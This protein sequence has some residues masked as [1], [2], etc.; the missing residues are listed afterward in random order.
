MTIDDLTKPLT[1]AQV[2]TALYS[3]MVG[4]GLVTTDWKPWA[5]VR[6]IVSALAIVLAALTVL[7]ALIAKSGFLEFARGPWLDLVARHVYG[8]ERILETFATGIVRVTNVTGAGSFIGVQTGDLVVKATTGAAAGKTY[9]ST[10]G[11]SLPATPGAFVD[12]PVRADE[13]GS[14]SSTGAGT[15]TSFVTTFVGCSVSNAA[16]LVGSDEERDEALRARARAK[17]GVLSPNGPRD[18]YTYLATSAKRADGTAIGVTRVRC[19]ADGRGGVD[20]YVAD[21]DGTITGTVGDLDSDLGIVDRDIQEQAVPLA[22][23]A[24]TH[25]STPSGIAVAYELWADT[26]IG[27]AGA[28]LEA[29][30]QTALAAYT[31]SVPIGGERIPSVSGGFVYRSAIAGAISAVVGTDHL[32]RL[33]LLTPAADVAVPTTAAPVLGLVTPEVHL[34]SS[35]GLV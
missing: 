8:V 31:S 11:F 24:R 21:V 4:R 6:T 25:A 12:V 28:E 30:I 1:P 32:I 22:V 10:A 33:D 9:R 19:I 16:A 18:A 35:A 14:A 2:E 17:T 27:L 29:A 5:V 15:I 20:V 7:I 26:A 34:V 23:T 13:A 3:A